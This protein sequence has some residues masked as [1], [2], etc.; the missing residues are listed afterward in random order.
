M[1]NDALHDLLHAHL[2]KVWGKYAGKVENNDDPDQIGRLQVTC[3]AVL[4]S[5]KVWARPCVPY[6]GPGVGFYMIPPQGAGV[7]IE[8]EGGDVS[9]AIWT[10]CYWAQGDAPSDAVSADTKV[11]V[12]DAA[13]LTID[14]Q[15]GEVVVE[16]T[17]GATTTWNSD[18][19]SEA[20]QATLTVGADGVV[21][22][23][24]SGKVAVDL[25]GVTLNDGAFTVS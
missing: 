3:E 15:S 11:I 2:S 9:R 18:V 5:E 12:T 19:K 4:G 24:S 1:I 7:W 22:E 6:A 23:F 10:G 8:F 17:N 13:K 14:D 21:S 20:G 25:S 16:N